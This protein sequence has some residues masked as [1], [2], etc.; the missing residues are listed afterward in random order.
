MTGN[1]LPLTPAQHL[2]FTSAMWLNEQKGPGKVL[3]TFGG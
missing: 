1:L 2:R 3:L